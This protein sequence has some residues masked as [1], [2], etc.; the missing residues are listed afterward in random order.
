MWQ[1][2]TMLTVWL[3]VRPGVPLAQAA[4][5]ASA[6]GAVVRVS[7]RWLHALGVNAPTAA[8]RQLARE[9]LLSRIQPAGRWR[10]RAG[11]DPTAPA[12]GAVAPVDT[13]PP[14]GGPPRGPSAMPHR[15]PDPRPLPA[16]G[17]DA[18]GRG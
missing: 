5:Q 9:A 2:D 6:T 4:A 7:S 15:P 10:L 14:R 8:L 13:S 11:P 12:A 16:P 3:F 1:R 17:Y 18:R